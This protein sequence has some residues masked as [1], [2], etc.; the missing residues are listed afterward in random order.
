MRKALRPGKRAAEDAGAVPIGALLR[1]KRQREGG[2][3]TG[4]APSAEVEASLDDRIAAL[5][6]ELAEG[7]SSSESDSE[8]SVADGSSEDYAA[9]EGAGVVSSLRDEDRI[10]KLPS[11]MLP[12]KEVRKGQ[13]DRRAPPGGGG[14]Q[15]RGLDD[16]V[17]ELVQSYVPASRDKLPFFCRVCRFR[18][19]S[20]AELV[21]HRGTEEHAAALARDRAASFCHMCRKQ[22]T[23]PDQLKGH[24]K[25]RA[26]REKLERYRG[27]EGPARAPR[28]DDARAGGGGSGWGRGWGRGRGRGRDGGRGR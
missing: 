8:G 19:A 27:R 13:K 11:H 26:H 28:P 12:P 15:M 20:E 10:P 16:A 5:E 14:R 1:A 18:G 24:L 22:F 23:S 17:R 25:G 6:R 2:P 4:T 7:G 9:G 21:A 3:P